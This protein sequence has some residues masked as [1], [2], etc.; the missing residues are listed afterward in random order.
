MGGTRQVSAAV[1]MSPDIS[2]LLTDPQGGIHSLLGAGGASVSYAEVDAGQFFS[3]STPSIHASLV[4]FSIHHEVFATDRII[5]EGYRNDLEAK[6]RELVA[7][8]ASVVA[9]NGS[10]VVSDDNTHNYHGV[11]TTMSERVRRLNL[12]LVQV[13]SKTGMSVVDV[14]RIVAEKGAGENVSGTLDYSDVIVE[15]VRREFARIASE[16]GFGAQGDASPEAAS[17]V[18]EMR[19]PYIN[20]QMSEGVVLRWHAGEGDRVEYG[21][22]VLDLEVDRVKLMLRSKSDAFL[23]SFDE[24]DEEDPA[25]REFRN[26]TNIR[27]AHRVVASDHG[28]LRRIEA[29][30]GDRVHVGDL[31]ALISVAP[32]DELG[33]EPSGDFRAVIN[34]LEGEPS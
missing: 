5:D 1:V 26:R 20:K 8:G 11:D 30:P 6:V 2:T 27:V 29:G 24:E 32:D 9:L 15:E 23:T 28:Y 31:L 22:P 13:S 25:A 16:I 7:S 19:M 3:G 4:V 14:D 34:V 21:Q 10:T 12:G 17:G 33:G 18:L